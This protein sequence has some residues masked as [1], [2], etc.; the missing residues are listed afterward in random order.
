MLRF[1]S[2][3]PRPTDVFG[4]SDDG[5]PISLRRLLVLYLVAI[6]VILSGVFA[7]L[8]VT[9][10]EAAGLARSA[11]AINVNGR[12]RM[13]TQRIAYLS[14]TL[15]AAHRDE[16]AAGRSRAEIYHRDLRQ[17]VDQFEAGHTL[18]T[19]P[20]YLPDEQRALYFR[21]DAGPALGVRVWSYIAAARTILEAP[22]SEG[23][24][25]RLSSLE[26][27]GLLKDL[28]DV[29]SALEAASIKQTEW[30]RVIEAYSLILAVVVVMLEVVYIFVPGH[31]MIEETL[32][33]LEQR[34]SRLVDAQAAL[35]AS[36]GALED[37]LAE[38]TRAG[39]VSGTPA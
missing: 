39:K 19:S 4:A 15:T 16:G 1:L 8:V 11:N 17:A 30:L 35:T 6:F 27:A 14:N 22:G 31:R 26:R 18:L 34:N 38:Q 12:Q 9:Q 20:G 24:L 37:E 3:P 23:A 13:L 7:S 32:H 29:V 33:A 2:P 10:I 5:G 21:T 28:D 25:T 36:L